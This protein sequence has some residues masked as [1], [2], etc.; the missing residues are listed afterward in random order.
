MNQIVTI[1]NKVLTRSA[2]PVVNFDKKLH[3]ILREMIA[4]LK[5]TKNPKGVG[6]AAPQIGVSLQ[7]FITRPTAASPV[8]SFINPVIVSEEKPV[9][10]DAKKDSRL[11]GCLS[12][13]GIWGNVLR[14][15]SLSLLFQ[16]EN[17]EKHTETIDGFHA[18]IIQHETDHLKGVLFTQRVLEGKNKLYHTTYD[19]EG[20]EIL[21]E[22]TLK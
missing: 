16:D 17:G 2:K 8:R 5:A 18:T 21:E 13:P 14:A 12:I 6:L 4:T 11:E 22:I 20:K 15:P 7:I 10:E 1:P 19:K 3:T 9:L